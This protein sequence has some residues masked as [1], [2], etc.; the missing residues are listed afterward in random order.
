MHCAVHPCFSSVLA[1]TWAHTGRQYSAHMLRY[2]H[3]RLNH[4]TCRKCRIVDSH[5]SRLD[6]Q[7]CFAVFQKSTRG[8]TPLGGSGLRPS[9]HSLLTSGAATPRIRLCKISTGSLNG[10]NGVLHP[11]LGVSHPR[12]SGFHPMRVSYENTTS[13]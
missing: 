13:C 3:L 4:P 10:V 9:I 11:S 1:C 12:L 8:G 6:H 2:S 7:R 5:K